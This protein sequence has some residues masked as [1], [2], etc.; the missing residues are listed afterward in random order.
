MWPLSLGVAIW[1]GTTV[2]FTTNSGGASQGS[3]G[4]ADNLI[5][6][7]LAGAI[8]LSSY[9]SATIR[10]CVISGFMGITTSQAN[11]NA[12]SGTTIVDAE[13]YSILV[14]NCSLSPSVAPG[15]WGSTGIYLT[16]NS[17]SL[18]NDLSGWWCS[19][20]ISGTA[21]SI[22]SGRSEVCFFG[23]VIEADQLTANSVGNGN[24]LAGFSHE[25]HIISIYQVPGCSAC[26]IQNVVVESNNNG[27]LGWYIGGGFMTV[28][29][30]SISG[31]WGSNNGIYI[32][33]AGGGAGNLTFIG[34][35]VLNSD[36]PSASWR[37][38]AQAW[39][40]TCIQSNNPA[41]VYTFANLPTGSGSPTP[42]E[43]DQYN[44]SDCSTSTFLAT[45]AGSGTG[46]AAH[47]L[48]RWNA[49]S[50][51]WQVVG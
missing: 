30:C 23:L 7:P 13:S 3:I 4:S 36:T 8:R 1:T 17:L 28:M 9:N 38:P 47:R 18:V 41:L 24:L 31:H 29:G 45:A 10:D 42:N 35:D 25:S 6:A 20:R 32:P 16:N 21:N 5:F 44:I 22:L 43:G 48:V 19:T 34:V 11:A 12:S 2:T 51:L 40:G 46:A 37:I 49:V 33:D 50:S 27:Q 14:Q 15:A 26:T 39:W